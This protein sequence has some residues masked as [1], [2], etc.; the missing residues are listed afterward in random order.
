MKLVWCVLSY[1]VGSSVIL[2]S[3]AHQ[4]KCAQLSL[5]SSPLYTS[6]MESAA[7]NPASYCTQGNQGH[8]LRAPQETQRSVL[9]GKR[10]EA[11]LAL[12]FHL[13]PLP[14]LSLVTLTS[15]SPA[16][17]VPAAPWMVPT[18]LKRLSDSGKA[19]IPLSP[20]IWGGNTTHARL[21][22]FALGGPVSE[23]VPLNLTF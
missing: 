13:P 20:D 5:L 14:R 15:P 11:D 2:W 23:P 21:E 6:Q 8:K 1:L 7:L 16:L 17:T 22:E 12:G 4:P 10:R 18:H 9:A 3:K 19:E